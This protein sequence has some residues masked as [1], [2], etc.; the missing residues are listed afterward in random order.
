VNDGATFKKG[1]S[2]AVNPDNNQDEVQMPPCPAHSSYINFLI[3]SSYN[4]ISPIY[5]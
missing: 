2:I 3:S 5:I 4:A 1:C